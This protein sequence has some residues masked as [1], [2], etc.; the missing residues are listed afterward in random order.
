[1]GMYV[2][3]RTWKGKEIQNKMKTIIE[4]KHLEKKFQGAVILKD[5]N[6][7]VREGEFIAV[8]GQS[9]CGKSTLLYNLSGMDFPTAGTVLF[10]GQ[11]LEGL[12]EPQLSEIRLKRMGFVFQR[13]NLLTALSVMD[14]VV[15]PAY[16]AGQL[17]RETINENAKQW[18]ARTG[19]LAVA[20]HDVRKISGGQ[21]QR[22]AICRALM[23][24]PQMLFA[25][26]PT[27]ALNSSATKEIMGIFNQINEE[28][29]AILLV[30][31]DGKVAARA[32]RV[33]YLEDGVITKE[34]TLG[35]Y[36]EKR[37]S[38]REEQVTAFMM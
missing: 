3:E 18:M 15:F 23:N 37:L 2:N 5:V 8:M 16:Q 30:T 6:L 38:E 11:K 25:D 21:Q 26:E 17:S 14:N 28:G 19:I 35:K 12:D 10:D 31:H 20:G 34:L 24:R 32:D 27:G 36:S 9:G 33:I 1:M 7:T 22:A 4:A 29:T 13:A